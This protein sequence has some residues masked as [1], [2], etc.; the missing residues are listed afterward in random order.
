MPT[1]S[2]GNLSTT[3]YRHTNSIVEGTFSRRHCI[4]WSL[5]FASSTFSTPLTLTKDSF[6]R[7]TGWII[8]FSSATALFIRCMTCWTTHVWARYPTISNT[9]RC[10]KIQLH[11]ENMQIQHYATWTTRTIKSISKFCQLC[12][13]SWH[14]CFLSYKLVMEWLED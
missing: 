8:I 11:Q 6:K 12:C 4:A 2:L 7:W 9:F 5:A 3:F 14:F 1:K 13:K 10:C